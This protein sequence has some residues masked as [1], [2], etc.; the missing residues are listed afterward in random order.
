VGWDHRWVIYSVAYLLPHCLLDCLGPPVP[1]PHHVCRGLEPGPDRNDIDPCHTDA[2]NAPSKRTAVRLARGGGRRGG[3]LGSVAP[4]GVLVRLWFNTRLAL[5][6]ALHL[7]PA[8]V[9]PQ[10]A[11]IHTGGADL[12]I[13]GGPRVV[14]RFAEGIARLAAQGGAPV[15]CHIL[16]APVALL[17]VLYGRIPQRGPIA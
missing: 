6:A 17:L 8:Y 13:R 14:V 7:T 10:T 9:N 5:R 4:F 3:A 12:W 11:R 16:A 1:Q 15:D 2:L